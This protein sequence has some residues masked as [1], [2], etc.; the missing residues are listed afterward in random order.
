MKRF[1]LLFLLTASLVSGCGFQLRGTISLPDSIRQVS[2]ASPDLRLKDIIA[3]SLE[4]NNVTVVSNPTATS[5]H[6]KIDRADIAREV[7]TL[8]ERGK[9]TGY[10]L[11]LRVSYSVV[12]SAGEPLIKPTNTAARR[13]YNFDAEQLLSAT[14]EEEL[15]HDEMREEAAQSILRKMSRIR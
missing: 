13:D 7:K 15:Y 11:I 4:A 8:D 1:L 2:I 12:D 6:I 9:S 10:I 5:A 14:R 3:D